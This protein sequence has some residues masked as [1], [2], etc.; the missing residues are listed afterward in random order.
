MSDGYTLRMAAELEDPLITAEQL[1]RMDLDGPC[2]LVRGRIVSV[3]PAGAPHTIVVGLVNHALVQHVSSRGLG[4]VTSGE[5]GYWV[6][7]DPDT[8]RAPDLAFLSH[9]TLR[10]WEEEGGTFFPLA[11]DLAVEVLS[12]DDSWS[13]IEEKVEEYLASGGKL[14]WVFVPKGEK[15]YVYEPG[16]P[17]RV[18]G[19]DDDLTADPVL[20]GFRARVSSLFRLP[21]D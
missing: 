18:L 9:E 2:E 21:R 13:K 11:P 16:S 1:A 7:R 15:V 5:G 3:S 14:V 19:P 10:R 20:P 17:G 12:P 6:A 4:L 8:V